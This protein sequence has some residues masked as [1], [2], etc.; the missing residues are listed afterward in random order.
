MTLRGSATAHEFAKGYASA[1]FAYGSNMNPARVQQRGLVV[2]EATSAW[3]T[4]LGLRFNKASAAH[5]GSGHANV[6]YA[7]KERVE[8]VLYWLV[9]NQQIQLIDP[10]EA[11]PWNYGRDALWVTPDKWP[12]SDAQR[13]SKASVKVPAWTYFANPAVQQT[14]LC[15]SADYLAHLL[16]G[17]EFLSDTYYQVLLATPTGPVAS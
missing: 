10:F 4:G 14:G 15:P 2:A 8:G 5:A 11:A 1:Y 6:V 13:R 16:A 12:G 3:V 17:R 9:D 7:P